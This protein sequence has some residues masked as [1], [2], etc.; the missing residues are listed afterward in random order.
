MTQAVGENLV[1]NATITTTV[2]VPDAHFAQSDSVYPGPITSST[3]W[4]G[5][6]YQQA[7]DITI[8]LPQVSTVTSLSLEFHQDVG[9]GIYYPKSVEFEVKQ[10]GTWYTIG[11]A[12]GGIPSTDR[13][14]T[15]QVFAVHTQPIVGQDFRIHVPVGVWVFARGLKIMGTPGASGSG[16]TTSLTPVS[17]ASGATGPL[18]AN[19]P[20]AQGIKNMLLIS[21]M[22]SNT[23]ADF[24]PMVG[25]FPQVPT[26]TTSPA[27]TGQTSSSGQPSTGT[28]GQPTT[29]PTTVGGGQT[30]PT[31]PGTVP[32]T[33][34]QPSLQLASAATAH[35]FDTFLFAAGG[36]LPD[37]EQNW[38]SYVDNL[39]ASG[40]D[41]S[42]LNS[43]VGEVN[44]QLGTPSYKAKVV[45][46]I[47]YPAYGDGSFGLVNG[48][49]LN[50]NGS[51]Q[52]PNAVAAR[53][54]AMNWI[55]NELMSKWAS[56]NYSNLQLVGFY[57]ENESIPSP[58]PGEKQLIQNA[59][60]IT[61]Q[62]NLP[63]FWIPFY[64]ADHALEWQSAG[65]SA[66]WLQPNFP[67]LGQ[68]A[69]TSRLTSAAQLA[70][71]YGMGLEMELLTFNPLAVSLYEESLQFY[72]QDGIAS[73]TSH[74]YYDAAHFLT[75]AANSSDP[76]LR[77]LYDDTYQF[78]Q[79]GQSGS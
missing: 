63:L 31:V 9:S 72:E 17:P 19:S 34:S 38:Q 12:H 42:A 60:K 65:F 6:N 10:N 7:R 13:R 66:A 11:T 33:G 59:V 79:Q 69:S 45:L 58:T 15:N 39:Y 53:T 73:S 35:M 36:N 70:N 23:E 41:L 18:T 40:N 67:E 3:S 68:S 32:T 46:T 78:I 43:A 47:P 29:Q 1:Q 74:A 28:T 5:Y 16:A 61:Q 50:F 37:N 20:G 52:D 25:Y 56:A 22:V 26:Q 4:Q 30:T 8:H 77:S 48:V 57:W 54:T 24:L 55:V 14:V 71:Q 44:Q 75:M 76:T 64:G 27:Q 2:A 62:Y 49:D 51:P 21:G